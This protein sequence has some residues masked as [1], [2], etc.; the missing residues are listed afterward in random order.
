M[1]K[2]FSPA[3]GHSTLSVEV[4]L[5]IGGEILHN[6]VSNRCERYALCG[7]RANRLQREN[8]N[9]ICWKI[10]KKLYA[11]VVKRDV[12]AARSYLDDDLM[13][14]GF[15]E[16]Y[17]N[18]E[19]YIA[20]MTKLLQVV[21]RLDVKKIMAEGSDAAVFFELETKAPVE[22]TTLVA[23]WHQVKN[24]KISRVESAFD[25]RPFAAMFGGGKRS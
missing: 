16:T 15:F 23:E 14:L 12:A 21:V 10:L 13:F 2:W 22:A 20:A 24:G 4:D 6:A 25:G 9:A 5:S 1:K 8:N 11:A 7:A 18:A 3:D 19:E 17:R